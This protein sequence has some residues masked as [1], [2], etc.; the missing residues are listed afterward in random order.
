MDI[1]GL[2]AELA[3]EEPCGEDLEYDPE[4]G[5]LERVARGRPEQQV[6][7]TLISAE[8]PDWSDV[9]KRALALFGRTKD[10]RV[11]VLLT[12]ALI[13]TDGWAGFRDGLSL[14]AGLLTRYWEG[15]YPRLDPDDDND[16]TQRINLVTSLADGE[17]SLR[18]LRE[19]PL[20]ASVLGRFSLRDIQIAHGDL[21]HPA[22]DE[23]LADSQT[24]AAGFKAAALEDLQA[25]A[26]AVNG[27][28]QTLDAIEARLLDLV[29]SSN[30]PDLSALTDMIGSA[31]KALAD[32]LASRP[33]AAA[34]APAAAGATEGA[35]VVVA[36]AASA[37]AVARG[38]IASRDDVRRALENIC[39]YY[40]EHEPA[41]PV[42]LLLH[43]AKRLIAKDFMEIIR[44]LAP[45]GVSQVEVIR[46]PQEEDT[47]D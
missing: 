47:G 29:G 28:A 30:A 41:S 32:G 8:E 24:V 42:P 10:L 22:G 33:D 38:P 36:A 11:A 25:V 40:R 46:G 13:R 45:D 23:A 20:V 21:A 7:D 19:A 2:L 26:D 34:A 14:V 27:C 39:D 37:A 1:E 35:P 31:S 4:F 12:D 43:R 16:P 44:D 17:T 9:R 15:V 5:A 3:P 18:Y 6:G